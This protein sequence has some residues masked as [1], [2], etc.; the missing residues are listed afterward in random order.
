MTLAFGLA[1]GLAAV[2]AVVA[3]PSVPFATDAGGLLGVNALVAALIA[4]FGSPWASFAAGLG[5]GV[6][7]A[8]IA[9]AHI[10]GAQ[11]G[12]EYREVLPIAFALLLVAARSWR[13]TPTAAEPL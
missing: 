9:N 7:E 3:A 5:V 8:A 1:G 11:L 10:G 2:A 12:P 13:A 4:R 6:V